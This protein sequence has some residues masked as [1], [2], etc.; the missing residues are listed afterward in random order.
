MLLSRPV[1]TI[2]VCDYCTR[3]AQN[4]ASQTSNVGGRTHSVPPVKEAELLEFS[5]AGEEGRI[6][7]LWEWDH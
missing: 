3:P 4:Q 5:V 2:I 1:T 7:L 6:I